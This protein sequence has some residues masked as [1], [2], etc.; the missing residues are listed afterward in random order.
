LEGTLRDSN[1]LAVAPIA[2]MERPVESGGPAGI[3]KPG[4]ELF[5]LM[6]LHAYS[7]FDLATESRTQLP[8]VS[9]LK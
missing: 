2:W 4:P 1:P 5:P 3:R 6:I 9:S 8:P 7:V